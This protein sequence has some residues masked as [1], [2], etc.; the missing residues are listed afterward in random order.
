M[1]AISSDAIGLAKWRRTPVKHNTRSGASGWAGI[2]FVEA[3]FD[4]DDFDNTV[5]PLSS[6]GNWT[7]PTAGD[8]AP[9]LVR[10]HGDDTVARQRRHLTGFPL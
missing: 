1:N 3:W 9:P 8:L 10:V 4:L 7:R 5:L 2:R 6:E